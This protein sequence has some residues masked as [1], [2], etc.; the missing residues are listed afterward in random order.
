M[1]KLKSEGYTY[2]AIA[3]RVGV[4]RQRIQQIIA[5]SR[6]NRQEILS[7]RH[8]CERCGMRLD[9][10]HLHHLDY[11]TI[12]IQVLCPKCHSE[13]RRKHYC[14]LCHKPINGNVKTCKECHRVIYQTKLT[15]SE[16]GCLY[17]RR[18]SVASQELKQNALTGNHYCSRQCYFNSLKCTLG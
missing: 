9:K 12:A 15:C 13:V 4:S 14:P 8:F 11:M 5:P 16:C 10:A 1:L 18:G 3:D 2:Q 17:T 7:N 6:D